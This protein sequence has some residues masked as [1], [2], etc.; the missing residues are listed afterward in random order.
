MFGYEIVKFV[1][2]LE[3]SL[4]DTNGPFQVLNALREL[5]P[6]EALTL[7]VSFT[8]TAGKVVSPHFKIS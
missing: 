8:P 6:D 2:Q 1:F 4:L 5:T 3:L 7:L